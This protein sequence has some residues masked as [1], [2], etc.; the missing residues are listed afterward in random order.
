MNR[1][2]PSGAKLERLVEDLHRDDAL[3]LEVKPAPH[4]P[5]AALADLVEDLDPTG[6]QVA[7]RSVPR[8]RGSG[9]PRLRSSWSVH[10]RPPTL[11]TVARIGYVGAY[12]HMIVTVDQMFSPRIL[13]M[14]LYFIV[15][16]E[17]DVPVHRTR[18]TPSP[19][20]SIRLGYIIECFVVP[21]SDG[22]SARGRYDSRAGPRR[23]DGR[24]P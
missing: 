24:R 4:G 15:E 7:L 20:K 11:E 21:R 14:M 18:P 23:G 2:R 8:G 16:R 5:H 17:P 12:L 13:V 6:E 19:P 22:S 3:E 10:S 1:S 9:R